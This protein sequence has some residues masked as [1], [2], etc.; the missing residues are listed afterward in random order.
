M[1][2]PR[3]AAARWAQV[4][5]RGWEALDPEP[6]VALYGADATLSTEPFR[7]PYRGRDGVRAYVAR[8]FAEEAEPR[9]WMA[10]PIVDGARAAISWWAALR[11]D[12]A[13]VT[14]AGTSSLRFDADGLVIEQWDAWN[15]HP[16]RR[17]PS[18]EGTPFGSAVIPDS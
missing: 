15:V 17:P 5:K 12:G 9:V 1:T 3:S 18:P 11:D 2:D 13:D 16:G 4:W 7:E 10:E 8:V 6:V 14:L